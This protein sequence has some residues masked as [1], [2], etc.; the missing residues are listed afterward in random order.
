MVK[1]ASTVVNKAKG[2]DGRKNLTKG[3][4][5]IQKQAGIGSTLPKQKKPKK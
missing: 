5:E 4:N 1:K 2:V 3:V